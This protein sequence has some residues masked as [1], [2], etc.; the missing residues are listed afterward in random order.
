[1]IQ[2]KR[3]RG[4]KPNFDDQHLLSGDERLPVCSSPRGKRSPS[5]ALLSALLFWGLF[6]D[7]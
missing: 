5:P 2:I 4:D 6:L 1:M 7:K 3:S